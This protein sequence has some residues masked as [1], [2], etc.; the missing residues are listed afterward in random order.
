MPVTFTC[1]IVPWG[2][3]IG[4][5]RVRQGTVVSIFQVAMDRVVKRPEVA[6]L[7]RRR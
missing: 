3:G 6:S 2:P 1:A 7:G 5:C 4:R